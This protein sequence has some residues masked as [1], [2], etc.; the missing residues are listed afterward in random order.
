MVYLFFF[1]QERDHAIKHHVTECSCT[2]I[3]AAYNIQCSHRRQLEWTRWFV[4]R[5]TS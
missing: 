2:G 3:S 1:D 5:E 4:V